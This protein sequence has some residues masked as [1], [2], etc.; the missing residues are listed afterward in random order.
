VYE[1]NGI[2][3]LFHPAAVGCKVTAVSVGAPACEIRNTSNAVV[4][5][6]VIYLLKLLEASN[7]F[8]PGRLACLLDRR[9]FTYANVPYRIKSSQDMLANSH[10]TIDFD[11]NIHQQAMDLAASLGADGLAVTG[12]EGPVRANLTEKLLIVALSKLVNYI[13]EAGVWMNTQRPEWND[14][15]NALVGYGVSMVTLCYLRRYLAFCRSLFA[16]A[17]TLSL[18]VASEILEQLDEVARTLEVYLPLASRPITPHERRQ[19]LDRLGLA[20]SE[21]R[22][23]VY[24]GFSGARVQVQVKRLG[25]F[26]DVALRHINRS[27]LV[28]RREDGLYHSYNL[29]KLVGDGIE[30]RHLYEMLEGQVA[31]LSSGALSGEASVAVLDALRASSLYRADQDSYILYP[32]H[33]LPRFL[34]KNILPREAVTRSVLLRA[35]TEAEDIRIIRQDV[36]GN[37]HFN[38]A[39][40]NVAGLKRSLNLLKEGDY[41]PLVEQE[42]AQILALYE[43]VF[44]H[45]S[46]TGRSGTFYKYE[47][48]GCIYWHMVSKLLLAVSETL[49]IAAVENS[50]IRERLEAHYHAIRAGLGVHKSPAVHGAIPTDPYS[51]TTGFAGAQQPGMTGQVKEDILSRLGE[52]GVQIDQGRLTFQPWRITTREFLDR[53][54]HFSYVDVDGQ[55]RLLELEAGSLAITFCQVPVVL[56]LKGP[57]RIKMTW[58]GGTQTSV[59]ALSLDPDSSACVFGRNG[60]IKRLDVYLDLGIKGNWH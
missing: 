10:S 23:K 24:G 46:F 4:D 12:P 27:I 26:C 55:A 8:N 43:Q 47:G 44:D 20:G 54:M 41:R 17:A 15:N 28:N 38:A 11:E 19:V 37:F 49:Q 32:D 22:T 39:F 59:D 36:E 57:P 14:A 30:I 6:Q 34:E 53:E 48:L 42:E 31:V 9:L 45:Q 40:R 2:S 16:E 35:L 3:K 51:H 7:R 1:L 13:P 25:A 29:M 18:E 50:S 5:H 21:Y 56:H 33:P 58:A 52:M 60:K